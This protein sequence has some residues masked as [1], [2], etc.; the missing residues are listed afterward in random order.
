MASQAL[1]VHLEGAVNTPR[2]VAVLR[3]AHL[4]RLAALHLEFQI[5]ECVC[6]AA[7]PVVALR[8]VARSRLC[9]SLHHQILASVAD[10]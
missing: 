1:L 7:D 8:V 10:S 3:P 2:G 4:T 5:I 9:F 6:Q